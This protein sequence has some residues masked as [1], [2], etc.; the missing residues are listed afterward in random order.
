MR[1]RER[2]LSKLAA[3]PSEASACPQD[4]C[5]VGEEVGREEMS[6]KLPT[7]GHQE[8]LT[9]RDVAVLFTWDE[10]RRLGPAQRSL[11]REV[12]LETFEHLVALGLP[13]FR[14]DVI[15]RLE[16]ALW[17]GRGPEKSVEDCGSCPGVQH[18]PAL[19]LP[20][21]PAQ[22]HNYLV[23]CLQPSWGTRGYFSIFTDEETEAVSSVTCPGSHGRDVS[24]AGF[25][26]RS[27][28]LCL[29]PPWLQ[30]LLWQVS[31]PPGLGGGPRWDERLGA[32]RR[33][34][35]DSAVS[36]H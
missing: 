15:S 16:R 27:P 11:Y 6:P 14:S 19:G 18:G 22:F 34:R 29:W 31:G 33:L 26:L 5:P 21:R 32:L 4:L 3:L 12:M 23:E 20:Q 1:L 2:L 10:W 35:G 17:M 24:E 25:E 8:S 30:A 9:F 13:G 28:A 36:S 7:S